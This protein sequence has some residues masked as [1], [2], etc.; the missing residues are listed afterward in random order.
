M[1]TATLF[2]RVKTWKQPKRPSADE[3]LTKMCSLQTMDYYSAMKKNEIMTLA[4]TWM[5]LEIIILSEV[6]LEKGK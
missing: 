5:Y 2:P 4:V 3:W 6:K 1:F